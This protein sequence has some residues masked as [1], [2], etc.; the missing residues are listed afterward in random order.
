MGTLQL[1]TQQS[2]AASLVILERSKQSC[3][4]SLNRCL[5]HS[6]LTPCA[7]QGG[8]SRRLGE[9]HTHGKTGAKRKREADADDTALAEEHSAQAAEEGVQGT[10][11]AE[12]PDLPQPPEAVNIA[13]ARLAPH[14][15]VR[16]VL[17][18]WCDLTSR[19]LQA[20]SSLFL[21]Q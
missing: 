1:C 17:E 9:S 18:H 7:W 14:P 12:T 5:Q 8:S 3:K 21:G 19:G 15:Q 11:T 2:K 10:G 13:M 4:A 20:P 16:P 6:M